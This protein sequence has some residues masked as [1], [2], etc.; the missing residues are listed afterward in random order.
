[1]EQVTSKE[2]NPFDVD[3]ARIEK[4]R[5]TDSSL[6]TEFLLGFIDKLWNEYSRTQQRLDDCAAPEPPAEPDQPAVIQLVAVKGG[7]A[8]VIGIP[9][10]Y[11]KLPEDHP[12]QHNC[13]A[14]GCT[15]VEHMLWRGPVQDGGTAPPPDADALKAA[16]SELIQWY[17]WFNVTHPTTK[18]P[19]WPLDATRDAIHAEIEAAPT[20]AP[21]QAADEETPC[22]KRDDGIHCECWYGG[23]ACCGC[24]DSAILNGQEHPPCSASGERDE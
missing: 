19:V 14:N 24:G 6:N 11:S 18:Y 8:V 4:V 15:S 21:E 5:R 10:H 23:N 22:P 12:W 2:L 3:L 17:R 9:A 1:M 20:K 16:R 7:R 13:D